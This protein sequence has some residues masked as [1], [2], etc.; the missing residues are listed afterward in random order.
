MEVRTEP[1]QRNFGSYEVSFELERLKRNQNG[2]KY[3]KEV[4]NNTN[5]NKLHYNQKQHGGKKNIISY[6]NCFQ[7]S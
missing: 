7:I 3:N 6:I 1:L 5:I 4:G 2:Y